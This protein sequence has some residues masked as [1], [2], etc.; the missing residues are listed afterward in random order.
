MSHKIIRTSITTN[1]HIPRRSGIGSREVV[2]CLY[3]INDEAG[4]V[5][6]AAS[7]RPFLTTQQQARAWLSDHSN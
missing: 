2:R 6:K 3:E 7:E 1:V 4:R 5:V